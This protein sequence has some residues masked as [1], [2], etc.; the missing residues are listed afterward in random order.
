MATIRPSASRGRVAWWS[1][2]RERPYSPVLAYPNYT[3]LERDRLGKIRR[4]FSD[5][6]TSPEINR[7]RTEY[8]SELLSL[9]RRLAEDEPPPLDEDPGT[10]Y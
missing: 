10:A 9:P 1:L 7:L 6:E 2:V 5:L 4:D 3:E 8:E